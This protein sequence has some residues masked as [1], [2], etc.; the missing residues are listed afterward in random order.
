MNSD[1]GEDS[2]YP[3]LGADGNTMQSTRNSCHVIETVKNKNAKPEAAE[4]LKMP[5]VSTALA[6]RRTRKTSQQDSL[7]MSAKEK[8]STK[9]H[10]NITESQKRIR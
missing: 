6:Q 5:P 9:A 2:L 3:K 8:Q 7:V 10:T 4:K 1:G